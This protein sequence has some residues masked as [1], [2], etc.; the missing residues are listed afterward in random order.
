M[1]FFVIFVDS[2]IIFTPAKLVHLFTDGMKNRLNFVNFV[3]SFVTIIMF[4]L[5]LRKIE[6]VLHITH[7]YRAVYD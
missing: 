7:K 2:D 5:I 3:V 6:F 4:D 1:R